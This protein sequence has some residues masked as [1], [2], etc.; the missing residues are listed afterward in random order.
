MH[1]LKTVL[2]HIMDEAKS[3]FVPGHPIIDNAIIDFEASAI[4]RRVGIIGRN[5]WR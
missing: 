5:L 2:P 1:R 4:C 3:G